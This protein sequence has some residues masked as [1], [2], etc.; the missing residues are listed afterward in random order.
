MK[1]WQLETVFC[2]ITSPKLVLPEPGHSAYA[3]YVSTPCPEKESRIVAA[4]RAV[5]AFFIRFF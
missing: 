1:K 4:C 3:G 5:V 2:R